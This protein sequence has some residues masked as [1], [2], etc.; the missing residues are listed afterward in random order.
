MRGDSGPAKRRVTR[1]P[2]IALAGVLLAAL[3]SGIAPRAGA[4]ARSPPTGILSFTFENDTFART[5]RYYTSGSRIS[6]Q[7]LQAAPAPLT[8]IASVLAP[9]LLPEAPVHWGFALGQT[10]HTPSHRLTAN[11]PRDDRPYAG[12]LY[13]TLSLSAATDTRFG[14][15]DLSIGAIGP[16]S[17]A[18]WVQDVVHELRGIERLGGW[19]HQI[20]NRAAGLLTFERRWQRN[21]SLGEGLEVGFVPAVGVNLGNVQTSIAAGFLLRAGRNLSV[22]FGPPRIRPALSG[23]GTF[24]PTE[25]LAWYAFAGVEGRAVAYDATLDGNHHG[26]WQVEREPLVA[27]LPFGIELVYGRSRFSFTWVL[28]SETFETQRNGPVHQ[29]G[30][31]SLSIAF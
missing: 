17:G 23:L 30:S 26:Y 19:D 1:E 27:E 12:H 2:R 8:A 25:G 16:S 6:W 21:A 29:F 24:R 13:G 7:S 5:D 11:P 14:S 15:V 31:A 20:G 4:E 22:D 9:A 18:G 28:Q 3:A 10:I